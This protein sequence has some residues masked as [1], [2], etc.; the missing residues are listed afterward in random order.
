MRSNSTTINGAGAIDS[1]DAI[2][3]PHAR[4][5]SVCH[6]TGRLDECARR[7]A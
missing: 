2:P 7:L 4:T 3:H 5:A 6:R 1:F